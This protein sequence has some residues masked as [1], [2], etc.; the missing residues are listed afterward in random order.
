MGLDRE[1][2]FFTSMRQ[3]HRMAIHVVCEIICKLGQQK[4]D[5]LR[6]ALAFENIFIT[7]FVDITQLFQIHY[8]TFI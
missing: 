7:M 6:D 1:G 3:S 4:A 8:T 2:G 5:Q